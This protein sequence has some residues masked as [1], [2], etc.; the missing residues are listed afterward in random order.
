MPYQSFQNNAPPGVTY[1]QS[2]NSTVPNSDTGV[3]NTPE[4]ERFS[5]GHSAITS[6]HDSTTEVPINCTIIPENQLATQNWDVIP[7]YPIP[8]P[9]VDICP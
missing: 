3:N 6:I 2:H 5:P 7:N 1:T 9:P 8:V 4:T